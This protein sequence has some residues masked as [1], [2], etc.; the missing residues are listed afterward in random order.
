MNISEK[1]KQ[2]I[3]KRDLLSVRITIKD[4]I[5]S[6]PTFK[7]FDKLCD[8]TKKQGV[9]IYQ[10]YDRNEFEKDISKWNNDYL[11]RQCVELVRNF[12]KERIEHL[13]EVCQVV[14]K[15]RIEKLQSTNKETK[16][17]INYDENKKYH[18]SIGTNLNKNI[19]AYAS[20]MDGKSTI[21]ALGSS[22]VVATGVIIEKTAVIV[23]GAAIAI[24]GLVIITI[25]EKKNKNK[26]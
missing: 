19:K 18:S 10:E 25:L 7:Q 26:K 6:D 8:Y 5:K 23:G 24:G 12:S 9:N 3:D 17:Y 22:A 4:T 13:R 21:A 2:D 14:Y 20:T 11:D 1:F 16:T 15:E